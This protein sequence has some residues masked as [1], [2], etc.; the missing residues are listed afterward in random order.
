MSAIVE[1][2][3]DLGPLPPPMLEGVFVITN[4]SVT[5]TRE[6][7][8]KVGDMPRGLSMQQALVAWLKI[9]SSHPADTSAQ[10]LYR[11]MSFHQVQRMFPLVGRENIRIV[12]G[13]QGLIELDRKIVPYDF[14]SNPKE[15]YNIHKVVSAEPFVIPMW[16]SW[17]NEALNGTMCPLTD[18]LEDPATNL[19]VIALHKFFF[20][21]LT[22]DLSMASPEGIKKLRIINTTTSKG[23]I[24]MRLRPYI[25]EAPREVSQAA[26]G[27]R[28]DIAQR[29]C[30]RF[31]ELVAA[32]EAVHET[33]TEQQE[34]LNKAFG[35]NPSRVVHRTY[36]PRQIAPLGDLEDAPSFEESQIKAGESALSAIMA[37]VG[38]RTVRASVS[39][40]VRQMMI[41]IGLFVKLLRSNLP[42]ARFTSHELSEWL[43]RYYGEQGKEL[44]G[45][46]TSKQR[47]AQHLLQVHQALGL[48][49][50]KIEGT[51][52]AYYSVGED[53][54]DDDD[55]AD[56][57]E[58]PSEVE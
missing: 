47:L 58:G 25:I 48:Q 36:T 40:D 51:S 15:P 5:R 21:Y 52:T 44:P 33:P 10:E 50:L 8:A 37:D 57:Q 24:P 55:D 4:C 17:V 49:K 12:T 39:R 2:S 27:N 3:K 46:V 28:N 18:L 9:L 45:W 54:D 35:L 56:A 16:W 7:V 1:D 11:G 38:R 42:G 32:N 29:A 20:K 26:I 34:I 43:T 22:D 19:V 14:S 13:G 31:L 53:P 6:P 41:D 30:M 23:Y